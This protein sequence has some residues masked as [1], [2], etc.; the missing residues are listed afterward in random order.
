MMTEHSAKPSDME[1]SQGSEQ[2]E[3]Q[4]L[5]KVQKQMGGCIAPGRAVGPPSPASRAT[6]TTSCEKPPLEVTVPPSPAPAAARPTAPMP[7]S[8]DYCTG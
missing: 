7:A 5:C 6:G 3:Q 2:E 1:P 8:R 4:G